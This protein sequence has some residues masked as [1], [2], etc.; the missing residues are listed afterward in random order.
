MRN[1]NIA[2]IILLV[3]A[4]LGNIKN[5]CATCYLY[6]QCNLI[7]SILKVGIAPHICL[8]I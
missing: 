8:V 6:M 1:E 5:M 3:V 2:H 4:Q 7:G